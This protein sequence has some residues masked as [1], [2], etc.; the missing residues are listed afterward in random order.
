MSCSMK[1]RI[2]KNVKNHEKKKK[3][4][5][6]KDS[7]AGK[8]VQHHRDAGCPNSAPFK[9]AVLRES[10]I[11][12]ERAAVM[13]SERKKENR[14]KNELK[15][16]AH[17]TQADLEKEALMKALA[18]EN[19]GSIMEKLA[20]SPS[21]E[22]VQKGPGRIAYYQEFNKIIGASDVIIQVL[23]AR[24]PIG[25]RLVAVE[26]QIKKDFPDKKVILLLNKIDLVPNN[27]VKDWCNY[28]G[29][30]YPT[31]A[32]KSATTTEEAQLM[33]RGVSR[34]M[35]LKQ[36]MG[37]A[38]QCVGDHSLMSLLLRYQ[39]RNAEKPIVVSFI[40]Y[41]GV[42]KRCV[43]ENLQKAKARGVGSGTMGIKEIN[44]KLKFHKATGIVL[45]AGKSD[46][47]NYIRNCVKPESI[48]NPVDPVHHILERCTTKDAMLYYVVDAFENCREFCVHLAIKH[49]KLRTGGKPN[50]NQSSRKCLNDWH[51]TTCYYTIAPEKNSSEAQVADY[52]F[53]LASLE[54]DNTN[55]IKKLR[56][57]PSRGF[58]LHLH[59]P[60]LIKNM[61]DASNDTDDD[62]D[63]SV[64]EDE[65]EMEVDEE[66]MS[67]DEDE[68]ST[69]GAAGVTQEAYD[70]DQM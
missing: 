51:K 8:V 69:S 36:M 61:M 2:R 29:N 7:A 28:L 49:G 27:I 14:M 63:E 37:N 12:K 3:K 33:Q 68:P 53:D 23:D 67:E 40:G 58:S 48:L 10:V 50:V 15:M 46:T 56:Q 62:D 20:K 45:A 70:F 22:T 24:D 21:L 17:S 66:M 25:T 41:P 6:K 18:V 4:Q 32:F 31:V 42:G 43:I 44:K 64:E 30:E 13:K 47:E 59:T 55:A 1:Y 35:V 5:A 11:Y 60:L 9:E 26:N 57:A 19:L 65:T 39:Q 54:E 34:Q 38:T 52:G 16:A